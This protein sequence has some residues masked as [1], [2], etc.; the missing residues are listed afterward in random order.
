MAM[1]APGAQFA[2]FHDHFG[3]GR[4]AGGG[5]LGDVAHRHGPVA[6]ARSVG[7]AAGW[8]AGGQSGPTGAHATGADRPHCGPGATTAHAPTTLFCVLAPN[9]PLRA[10]VTAMALAA[11][12]GGTPCGHRAT[13]ASRAS[14][15]GP[16]RAW[17]GSTGQCRSSPARSR[18]AQALTGAL[19]VGGVDRPI[20]DILRDRP[21]LRAANQLCPQL[22]EIF[23]CRARCAAGKCG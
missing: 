14:R 16:G 12:P 21:Q 9:S 17:G 23:R 2:L 22:I 1:R 19:P 15:D 7:N 6:V 20:P 18:A 5:D 11:P 8:C 10:A 3:V 13:R 4:R